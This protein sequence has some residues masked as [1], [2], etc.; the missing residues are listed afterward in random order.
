[1]THEEFEKAAYYWDNKEQTA[2]PE[3]ALKKAVLREQ[4]LRARHRNR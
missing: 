2:M 4:H 1:M 3:E